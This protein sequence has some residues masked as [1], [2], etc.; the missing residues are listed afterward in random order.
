MGNSNIVVEFIEQIWN[1]RNF[2]RLSEF[3]H[4]EFVDNSLPPTFSKDK[5]GM[6]KWIIGTGIS[7]QHKTTI[8]EQVSE[9]DK[10]IIKIKMEL[11][12]IGLWRDIEPTGIEIKT[13]GFRLFKIINGKIFEH[14][15][16]IDGQTIENQIKDVSHGCKIIK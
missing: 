9:G 8:E 16:L 4:D 6:K 14:W 15:A 3:L 13:T 12:H 1:N 11:K 7:F 2:E 5:E 10:S